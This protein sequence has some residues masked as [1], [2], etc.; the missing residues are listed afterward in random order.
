MNTFS[1]KL[2]DD[3]YGALAAEAK[4]RN[5]TKSALV[6]EMIDRAIEY[7]ADAAPPSCAQ[8]AGDLAGAFRS[9][10]QGLGT[11]DKLLEEAMIADARTNAP[12]R[13]R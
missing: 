7:N 2:P 11:D 9:G 1:F 6:R 8:L 5:I 3:M 10:R 13:R 4:R 12:D